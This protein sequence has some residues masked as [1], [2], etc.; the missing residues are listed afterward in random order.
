MEIEVH[1][2]LLS[3]FCAFREVVEY[4]AGLMWL[5]KVVLANTVT[6]T[7]IKLQEPHHTVHTVR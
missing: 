7:G 2:V 1:G 5:T 6:V 4:V 3:D